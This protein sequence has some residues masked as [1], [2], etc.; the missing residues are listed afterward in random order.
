MHGG[1]VR[2]LTGKNIDRSTKNDV[3]ASTELPYVTYLIIHDLNQHTVFVNSTNSGY[4]NNH[5]HECG[6]LWLLCV[7]S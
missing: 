3:R 4:T 1:I 2:Y 7:M 6:W 5:M